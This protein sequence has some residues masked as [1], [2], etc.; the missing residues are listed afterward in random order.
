[1]CAFI[2]YPNN[3]ILNYGIVIF[4]GNKMNNIYYKIKIL[5]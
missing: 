3:N 2:A 4:K 1:M 5:D